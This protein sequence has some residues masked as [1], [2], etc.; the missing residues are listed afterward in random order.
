M[1]QKGF[2]LVE[3]IVA[4]AVISLL[5]VAG[6]FIVGNQN[7][8]AKT[9]AA[10]IDMQVLVQ[11]IFAARAEGT[12]VQVADGQVRLFTSWISGSGEV[13]RFLSKDIS[14]YPENMVFS[15]NMVL[16]LDED[17]QSMRMKL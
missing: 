13:Q 2:S 12:S 6:A 15:G 11:A 10:L 5:T 3:L 14:D 4:V 9:S 8:Q 7:R 16:L 17:G 1:K